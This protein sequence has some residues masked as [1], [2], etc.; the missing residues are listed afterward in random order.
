MVSAQ[1]VIPGLGEL[2][3][4][5]PIPTPSSQSQRPGVQN[6]VSAEIV[7]PGLGG[8]V[9]STP[10]P[11]ASVSPAGCGIT[12]P[13]RPHHTAVLSVFVHPFPSSLRTLPLNLGAT[14]IQPEIL[15]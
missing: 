3:G 15:H 11:E 5:T 13:S 7:T 6:M 4:P 12:S 1:V 9:P 14:Q 8:G 10:I 2:G